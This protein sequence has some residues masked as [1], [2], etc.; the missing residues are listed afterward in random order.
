MTETEREAAR[1][2]AIRESKRKYAAK[3]KGKYK[4]ISITQTAEQTEADK[5][6]LKAKG[7][8]VLKVWRAAMDKLKSE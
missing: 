4:T 8:T 6:L 7:T 1:A 3:I 5:E 2:A